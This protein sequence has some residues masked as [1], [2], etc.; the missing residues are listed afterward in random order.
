MLLRFFTGFGV[1]NLKFKK[2]LSSAKNLCAIMQD[3]IDTVHRSNAKADA[4][5][6]SLRD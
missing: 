6:V 5:A 1:L 3:C 4:L 2:F